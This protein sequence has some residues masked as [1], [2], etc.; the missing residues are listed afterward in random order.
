MNARD[1]LTADDHQGRL[2][3][4]YRSV[5]DLIGETPV[6]ELTT[7]DTGKCRLFVKLEG[8][9]TNKGSDIV[10]HNIQYASGIF[11]MS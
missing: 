7:F 10:S 1:A 3:P 4:P 11:G 5:L 8:Y 9:G 6:I 2:K